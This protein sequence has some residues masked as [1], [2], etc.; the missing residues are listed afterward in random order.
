MS[1]VS[2][3]SKEHIYVYCRATFVQVRRRVVQFEK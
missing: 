2:S 1:R 3:L